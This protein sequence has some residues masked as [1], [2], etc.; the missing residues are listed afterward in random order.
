VGLAAVLLVASPTLA[1][2]L[3][4]PGGEKFSELWVLGS[5]SMAE[6]HLGNVIGNG[7]T[8]QVF[9]GVGNH[10]GSPSEYAVYVKLRNETDD[11]PNATAG[12]PS[13]LPS[14]YE[15]RIFVED[16]ENWTAPL[17][18]SISNVAFSGNSSIIGSFVVNGVPFN[19]NKPAA[20]DSANRGYYY[21]IFVE[22][23]IYDS[24]SNALQ[25]HNRFVGFW[26]NMTQSA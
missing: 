4:L 24:G 12:T 16:G 17:N 2:V 5:G 20:W 3:R 25:Y 11:L 18:F 26:L 6:D 9:L 14:L 7:T 13:S 8:Y 21:E 22:L 23:W 10:M 15:Y 19:V 1:L